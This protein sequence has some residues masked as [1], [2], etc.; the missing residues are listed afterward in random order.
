MT[1]GIVLLSGGLDSATV[2]GI[3]DH[4]MERVSALTFVYGQKADKEVECAKR[5]A[6]HYGVEEH[7]VLSIPLADV[8]RSSLLK[9]GEEIPFEESEVIPSTYVP[10]RNIILLSY[11]LSYAEAIDADSIYI[12]A[13]AVDFSGYPDCRPEFYE[14]FQKVVNEGTRKCVE[15]DSIN[16][17]VPLQNMSKKEIIKKADE[18][19]VPLELTWSCYRDGNKACGK[20]DSCRL[21][22]KGF[23]KAGLQDP[24]EY[25]Y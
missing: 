10:A 18:L 19:E 15:G 17:R 5:L 8:T 7:I 21:R 11:A 2:L 23:K 24:I 1:L 25:K 16:I 6:E 20:C 22:L 4:E 3:A 9:G 14:A 12:G 13:N